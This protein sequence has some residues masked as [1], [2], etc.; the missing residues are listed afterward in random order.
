MQASGELEES[1]QLFGYVN[2]DFAKEVS[3]LMSTT[4]YVLLLGSGIV[5]W[6]SKCQSITASTTAD[7]EFIASA[8]AIQELV[9]F[10]STGARNHPL[11]TTSQ[12]T[13]Q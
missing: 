2:A 4:G 9:W 1:F 6:H 12:F 7:T 3:S 8:S 5:Q 11:I 10:M 13:I